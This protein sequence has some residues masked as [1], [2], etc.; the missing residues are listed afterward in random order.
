MTK[1]VEKNVKCCS[2]TCVLFLLIIVCVVVM[3]T[4]FLLFVKFSNLNSSLNATWLSSNLVAI[5][6]MN[7]QVPRQQN[8][9]PNK[10]MIMYFLNNTFFEHNYS[11]NSNL[12]RTNL[13]DEILDTFDVLSSHIFDQYSN[14]R[15]TY[16]NN[17]VRKIAFQRFFANNGTGKLIFIHFHKAGGT[18]IR[19]YI[20]KLKLVYDNNIY[21]YYESYFDV[22]N[23]FGDDDTNS[24]T[25]LN[26]M[27]KNEYSIFMTC[28]RNPI[29]RIISQYNFE[30][31]W[32][33]QHGSLYKKRIQP[34]SMQ[35]K[36]IF[37]NITYKN[38]TFNNANMKQW[39]YDLETV[40]N[41]GYNN[42]GGFVGLPIRSYIDNHYL[43][44]FT[45]DNEFCN[46]TNKNCDN[47]NYINKMI[48]SIEIISSF[49]IVLITELL[50]DFRS[51]NFLNNIFY[52][53]SYQVNK[54]VHQESRGTMWRQGLIK[55]FNKNTIYK[56]RRKNIYDQIFYYFCKNMAF[57]TMQRY[58]VW[59]K[60]FLSP[61]LMS[62]PIQT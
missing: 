10:E 50:D 32:S 3:Q 24:E 11:Y 14:I 49:D 55:I 15:R 46:F 61:I 21:E 52:N 23:Q 40:I 7:K 62:N 12:Q 60:T 13:F 54:I 26:L 4:C 8:S 25:F 41:F 43:W 44:F 27:K 33:Q 51:E 18:S 35:Q 20:D 57:R 29:D 38:D 45:C 53:D 28:I 42:I 56:L 17:N 30:W 47:L 59:N 36:G 58:H 31:R 37:T 48:L 22:H 2:G 9:N 16:R 5:E 39:H 34:N 6:N 19:I 1:K